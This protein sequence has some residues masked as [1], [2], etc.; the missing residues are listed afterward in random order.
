MP[1]QLDSL[2]VAV[3]EGFCGRVTAVGQAESLQPMV[4]VGYRIALRHAVDPSHV[5]ELV[6][7][8]HLR[9]EAALFGHVSESESG[10]GR[11]GLA[12]P[13]DLAL[14]GADEAEDGAH[15]RR[16][17]RSVGAQEAEHAPG[18]NLERTSVESHHVAIALVEVDDL[19]H[20]RKVTC[21]KEAC[22]PSHVR[23]A[24]PSRG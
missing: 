6:V 22:R 11:D 5:D 10:V 2:L 13:P 1:R 9:V 19:E 17:A 24:D 8:L 12:L 3:G 16:L 14:V 18:A 23:Y 20:G 7:G 4:G 21:S 15:R